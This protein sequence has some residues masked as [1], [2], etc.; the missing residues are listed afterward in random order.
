MP[1]LA[2]CRRLGPPGSVPAPWPAWVPLPGACASTRAGSPARP[3]VL[4]R[5][6]AWTRLGAWPGASVRCWRPRCRPKATNRQPERL[7]ID[8]S[9]EAPAQAANRQPER[10]SVSP[11]S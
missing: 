10:L 9:D 7:G 11:S 8:P 3:G 6:N 5:P 4:A 1:G 2:P